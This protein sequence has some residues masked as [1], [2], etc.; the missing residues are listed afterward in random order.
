MIEIESNQSRLENQM[1]TATKE[2]EKGK[3]EPE[4]K[5]EPAPSLLPT[6]KQKPSLGLAALKVL[7]YGP[8][9]IGK[10]TLA[11]KIDPDS[12]LFIATEPG[13]GALEVFSVTVQTW[14]DFR[15]VGAEL[16]K[17]KHNFTTV[18]IDTVD[19]LYAMCEDHITTT[20]KV[21]YVGDLEYGKGWKMVGQEFQLRVAKLASLVPGVW[22]ISHAKEVEIKTRLGTKSVMQPTLS[23]KPRD[24]ITGFVDFILFAT[25]E[26]NEEGERRVLRTAAVE[27]IM[28]GGRVALPDPLPLDAGELAKA[29]QQATK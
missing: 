13:L 26:G 8:P 17:G 20:Q 11:S 7:L 22:F 1:A 18:V 10:S 25:S 2:P 16:A 3:A 24:F 28:A 9:K 4:K 14:E 21:D 19:N 5:K 23:G 6:A 27:N 15:K 12:T 29:I